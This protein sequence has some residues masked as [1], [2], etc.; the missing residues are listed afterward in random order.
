[1]EVHLCYTKSICM[2][3]LG[4][5]GLGGKTSVRKI[6]RTPKFWRRKMRGCVCCYIHTM[7]TFSFQLPGYHGVS[8]LQTDRHQLTNS[9]ATPWRHLLRTNASNS[10]CSKSYNSLNILICVHFTF[11]TTSYNPV[12]AAS[13]KC[14]IPK[15]WNGSII[16]FSFHSFS[17][18]VASLIPCS[19]AQ[20]IASHIFKSSSD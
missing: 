3:C 15:K 16:M 14:N 19:L 13:W 7:A 2:S 4:R 8:Q 9:N 20:R 18:W 17:V 11:T 1:M 12:L 5:K 6:H 10:T